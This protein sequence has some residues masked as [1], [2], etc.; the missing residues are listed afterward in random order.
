MPKRKSPRSSSSN[1]TSTGRI[2]KAKANSDLQL[3]NEHAAGIDIGADRH[4]VAVPPTA[5]AHPVREF[6]VFTKDLYALADWLSSCGVKTVAM[7]ST[8]V[9]WVP[10]FE[11]LEERGFKVKLVDARKVK[12]VSGRKSDV[13]DCQWLQQLESYGLLQGA[14]RPSDEIVVLRAYMRQRGMLVKSAASHILH[15]QKALQQM[16][17]R[18]DNVVSD[19]TGQTGMRILKAIIRGERDVAKLGAMRDRNCKATAEV[20]AQSLVGNYRQEHLFAL[21]QAVELFEIYQEKIRECELE[22]GNYLRTLSGKRADKPPIAGNP[23]RQRMS[24][25]VRDYAYR[26]TGVDLFRVQ[27]FNSQTVLQIISEVG[28]D[29][30]GFASEKQFAS[31]LSVSPNRRV[32]GGKVLS[33]RTKASNNRAAQAFRQAAVSVARSESELGAYYRRMQA[34]KGPGAAITATAHKLARLYYSLVKQGQ[35]YEEGRAEAYQERQ[36]ERV[37][38]SLRKRAKGL[39]Y[40]LVEIAA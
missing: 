2:L 30:S 10:L 9:Y 3:L 21:K 38:S 17:L 35:E 13:L 29:L 32:S 6:S 1:P 39:G 27:G 18:L 31:W 24:F 33:S 28:V 25:N 26:L 5:D 34:R 15:M 23:K 20:I 36:R 40:E 11:V 8:G 19:I 14:Y 12:N 16:N 37:V 4:Y 7:E 22:M